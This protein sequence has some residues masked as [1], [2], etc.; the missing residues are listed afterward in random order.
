MTDALPDELPSTPMPLFQAWLDEATAAAQ[1]PNPN[2]FVLSTAA[3][4]DGAAV[5]SA[6]VVL[7]KAVYETP[8]FIVF[9]TNYSS[10]KARELDDQPHAAA[11]FHWDSAGRQVRIAGPVVKSPDSESDAYFASRSWQSRLGAWASEQS[12]PVVSRE[13]MFDKLR[14]A[15][16]AH[17]VEYPY[18][19]GAA[20]PIERPPGWGG[21]RLW[22]ASV[23]LW[24]DGDARV[25]DRA[26]WSR[27]LRRTADG[28]TPGDWTA[29]RLQP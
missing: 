2:A 16:R 20:A 18:G 23:E 6:R 21:F 22:A 11:T 8:G 10:H 27:E 12:Q 17:G 7:C 13:A 3:V 24:V 4:D 15:W 19:N 5:P 14:A 29:T 28:F 1:T 9:Y 26:R 25:H